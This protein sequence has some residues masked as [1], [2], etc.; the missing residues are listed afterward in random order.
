MLG[1]ELVNLGIRVLLYELKKHAADPYQ[2]DDPTS[3]P[4]SLLEISSYRKPSKFEV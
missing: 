2:R 4:S 3:K 1:E